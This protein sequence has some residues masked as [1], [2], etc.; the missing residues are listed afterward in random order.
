MFPP[1]DAFHPEQWE[2]LESYWMILDEK[3][4]GCCAFERHADFEEDPGAPL[5]QRRGS[6]YI[7]STGIL[8]Q[9][10]GKGLGDRFKRWQ[11]GWARRH[12]FTRI[13]TNSRRSNRAMIRL[14]QKHG[15]RVIRLTA[16]PYYS[17]PAERAVVME[18]TLVSEKRQSRN[19]EVLA[20]LIA[21]RDCL[22][23]A[24]EA[25]S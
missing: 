5:P 17:N 15:F 12:G 14:N 25:L 9:W 1:A 22:E 24:I 6:L 18:R 23:R 8:E 20:R 10:R 3:R 11:I 21:E 16:G 2:H 4:V 19:D 7:V 13:V